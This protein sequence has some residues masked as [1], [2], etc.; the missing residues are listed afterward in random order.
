MSGA[1]RVGVCL[2]V[3]KGLLL[4][5]GCRGSYRQLLLLAILVDGCSQKRG[6]QRRQLPGTDAVLGV[7]P[8]KVFLKCSASSHINGGADYN[9]G[10]LENC[11]AAGSY[12]VGTSYHRFTQPILRITDTKISV[13]QNILDLR[14]VFAMGTMELD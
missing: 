4:P 11:S 2:R 13:C 7:P 9:S 14:P 5:S 8:Q 10:M 12:S 1:A 6:G 3:S